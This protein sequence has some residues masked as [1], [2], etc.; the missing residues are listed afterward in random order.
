MATLNKENISLG[1]A[2][3]FGISPLSSYQEAWQL[4]GRYGAEEGAKSSISESA[5]REERLTLG[6]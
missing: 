6:L 2:Y 3:K 5:G 1:L 4:T